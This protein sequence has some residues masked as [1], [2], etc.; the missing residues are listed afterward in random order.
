LRSVFE[1][2]AVPEDYVRRAAI[3]LV[4][5]P[6]TF[7][8]NAR[9]LALLERFIAAQVPHYV[10][11]GTPTVIITGDRDTMVSPQI[12]AR[13]LAATLPRAKLVL[14]KD[15]GHMPHHAAPEIVAAAIDELVPAAAPLR[16]LTR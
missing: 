8:S 5:R 14:L 7:Y 16:A 15:I 2:Q 9:D 6:K 4:L 11:L 3:R 12:N 13:A 1:P 10:E